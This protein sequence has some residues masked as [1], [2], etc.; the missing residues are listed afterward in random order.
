MELPTKIHRNHCFRPLFN[1]LQPIQANT[2]YHLKLSD[3]DCKLASRQSVGT[4]R[5]EG[6][7]FSAGK[8]GR[9][10]WK[11]SEQGPGGW[12]KAASQRSWHLNR[13]G[14]ERWI[15]LGQSD[16]GSKGIEDCAKPWQKHHWL[17]TMKEGCSVS[18]AFQ[19]KNQ[20]LYRRVEGSSVVACLVKPLVSLLCLP[21]SVL[22]LF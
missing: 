14:F 16:M 21:L 8:I 11:I 22:F 6:N 10:I 20:A 9:R 15:G 18:Q 1:C 19:E 5:Q 7:H 17:E 12:G 3:S 2:H 13:Q 4:N